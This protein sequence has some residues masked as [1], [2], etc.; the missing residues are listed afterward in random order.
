MLNVDD[1]FRKLWEAFYVQEK[2]E[3]LINL[4]CCLGQNN[5]L[6]SSLEYANEMN[7]G[8]DRPFSIATDEVDWS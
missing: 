2:T 4:F 7:D 8:A 3:I 6:Y 5:G 1:K